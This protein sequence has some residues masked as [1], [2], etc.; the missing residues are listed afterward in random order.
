MQKTNEKV[1]LELKK[2]TQRLTSLETQV[3][4]QNAKMVRPVLRIPVRVRNKLH[5]LM[6]QFVNV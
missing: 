6:S 2:K 5:R 4:K 3:E 1:E